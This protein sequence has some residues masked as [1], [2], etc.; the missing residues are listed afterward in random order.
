MQELYSEAAGEAGGRELSE[1]MIL[2]EKAMAAAARPPCLVLDTGTL[3][4]PEPDHVRPHDTS[5][6]FPTASPIHEVR[7]GLIAG[8]IRVHTLSGAFISLRVAFE[9]TAG[10]IVKAAA[11]GLHISQPDIPFFRLFEVKSNGGALL[12]S[13]LGGW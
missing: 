10:E 9:R 12:P 7:R 11:T 1:L 5:T 4:P 13:L 3:L 2:R 6:Q 8:I